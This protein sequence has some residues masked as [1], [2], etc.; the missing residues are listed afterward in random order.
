MIPTL[1][2]SYDE[3]QTETA[4]RRPHAKNPA[5]VEILNQLLQKARQFWESQDEHEWHLVVK[6]CRE[7]TSGWEPPPPPSAPPPSPD[8]IRQMDLGGLDELIQEVTAWPDSVAEEKKELLLAMESARN[9]L[10]SA[11]GESIYGIHNNVMVP[12]YHRVEKGPPQPKP[13]DINL[14]DSDKR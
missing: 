10:S 7:L 11:Q 1:T 13:K 14:A 6:Q 9:Q 4:F 5:D 8:K 12:L 2:P 3:L